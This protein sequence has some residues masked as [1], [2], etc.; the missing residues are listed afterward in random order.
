VQRNIDQKI[1][2]P[3]VNTSLNLQRSEMTCATQIQHPVKAL[4]D[5]TKRNCLYCLLCAETH[6]G[7]FYHSGHIRPVKVKIGIR[8]DAEKI[9]IL[10]SKPLCL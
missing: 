10:P 5:L 6:H 4:G 7:L 2:A 8:Q 9:H 1:H 3:P